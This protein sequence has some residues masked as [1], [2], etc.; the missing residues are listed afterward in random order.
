MQN[1]NDTAQIKV[2]AFTDTIHIKY[3]KQ[4]EHD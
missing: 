4:K 2:I 1:Y 3:N